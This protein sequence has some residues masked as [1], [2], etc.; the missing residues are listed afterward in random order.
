MRMPVPLSRAALL[1]VA[2]LAP[3]LS[4]S[5]A[6]AQGAR[7]LL[8][9]TNAAGT[10]V[11]DEIYVGGYSWKGTTSSLTATF[12]THMGSTS[13]LSDLS[14]MLTFDALWVD[15]RYKAA[16]SAGELANLAAFAATGRRVVVIG[17]NATWGPWN[18][19]VLGA[20]GGA[21]GPG[22][23]QSWYQMNG[24][25][26]PGCLD[27]AASTAL[28]HALTAGVAKVNM[29]CG[30]YALGGT[31]LFDYGVATLWGASQNVL[32]IL[33]ANVLDDRFVTKYDGRTFQR[34][35]VDWIA[36][37][38]TQLSVVATPE[39]AT[40]GLFAAGLL[41]VGATTV[42]RRRNRRT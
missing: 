41:A 39:P 38:N 37:P 4:A 10:G 36:A 42:K 1:L 33:D 20:L 24:H 28:A 40:L 25:T 14:Q 18:A 2:A 23:S 31:S 26:T 35:V 15:Q 22:Q 7:S 32:V 34:N 12:G 3:A 11:Y 17:E 5:T 30:G 16:P 13:T 21:E 29:S 19:A 9:N 8:V 6:R 27:G